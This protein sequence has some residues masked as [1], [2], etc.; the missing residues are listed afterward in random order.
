MGFEEEAL[1]V[2]RDLEELREGTIFFLRMNARG[3]NHQ[4]GRDQQRHAQGLVED[5][6]LECMGVPRHLGLAVLV[7]AH[8]DDA[9]LAG[10]GVVALFEA[11]G[12]DVPVKDVH[13]GLGGERLDAQGVLDGVGATHPGTV[14]VVGISRS[15]A[16]DHD[17]CFCGLIPFPRQEA[18]PGGEA[19]FEIAL[20][21]DTIVLSIQVFFWLV[22]LRTRGY[23]YDPVGDFGGPA[24]G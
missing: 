12:T 13:V 18:V 2:Q 15:H 17:D 3:Q 10:L 1:A 24:A 20:R 8:K 16:L 22:L 4:V 21:D 7:V 5:R 6:D 11:V 14:G 19:G 9:L 23:D